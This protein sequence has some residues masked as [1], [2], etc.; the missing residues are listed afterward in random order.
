MSRFSRSHLAI[1]PT[2]CVNCRL[3]E[4]SCPFD[5][6]DKPNAG[7]AREARD[8]GVRRLGY[9]FV[10]LPVLIALGGWIGNQMAVPMSRY[11]RTVSLAE[12]VVAEKLAPSLQPSLELETFR[13]KGMLDDDLIAQAIRIRARMKWG[14][15]LLGGFLGLVFGLKLI[16]LSTVRTQKD[17]QVNKTH[18]F[19]CARCCS[20]CP[21]DDLHKINFLAGS[22]ALTQALAL[23]KPE[24]LPAGKKPEM[25]KV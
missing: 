12:Q 1:T 16:G 11:N 13:G 14:G 24:H 19:S 22:P 9:F 18:C 17:F 3:C 15:S 7:L 2:A 4:T 5:Y 25:E 21:S 6:I 23:E 8:I 20:Y 10:M